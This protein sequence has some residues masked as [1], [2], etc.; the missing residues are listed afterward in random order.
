MTQLDLRRVGQVPRAVLLAA[1]AGLVLATVQIFAGGWLTGSTYDEAYHVE[2]FR[3]YLASGYYLDNVQ[4]FHGHPGPGVTDQYVY[5]PATMWLLHG[6]LRLFGLEGAGQVAATAHAYAFRHLAIGL[7]SVVGLYAV[8]ATGKALFRRWDWGI[9]AAAVVAVTPMW[10]GHSMFNL[11]DIPVATG[12]ALVTLALVHVVDERGRGWW[13]RLAD[14]VALAAG[15]TLCVGT[16]PGMWSGMLASLVAAFVLC[17][18]RR[19]ADEPTAGSRAAVQLHRLLDVVVGVAIAGALLVWMYPKVFTHP[20]HAALESAGSSANFRGYHATWAYVPV[21]VL[22]HIPLV[23][24]GFVLVGTVLAVRQVL[25]THMHPGV[26]ETQLALVLVQMLTLP[27][28]AVVKTSALYGDLRQLLFS[29]TATALVAT[30]GIAGVLRNV[31]AG[32]SVAARRLMVGLVCIGLVFPVLD[33]ATLFPFNYTYYTALAKPSEHKVFGDFYRAG[34]RA[35]TPLIPTPGRVVCGA[36]YSR[37]RAL[38]VQHLDGTVD[39]GTYLVSP[40]SPYAD[41]R[42]RRGPVLGPDQYY[43]LFFSPDGS[44]SRNCTPMD[45]VRRWQWWRARFTIVRLALCELR[46]PVL[47]DQG[48]TIRGKGDTWTTLRGGWYFLTSDG[49]HVR[50]RSIARES[51][52]AFRAPTALVGKKAVLQVRSTQRRLPRVVVNG[53]QVRARRSADG[54]TVPLAPALTRDAI[55]I[56]FRSAGAGPLDMTLYSFRME[57]A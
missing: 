51:A 31:R 17:L 56:S 44:V 4:Y 6:W 20:V 46:P 54:L 3:N 48:I 43:V 7:L 33:Q 53:R 24:L 50:T 28:V 23:I 19:R 25:R 8:A 21:Q 40:I 11:K 14:V 12:Y 2:R 42:T 47:P 10:T 52:L 30:I 16:R 18:V 55:R 37:D 1:W 32:A 57:P 36:D 15:F 34:G 49:D 5:G 38:F 13:A 41:A 27:L 45:Q 35:I 39:C 29:M 22:L 9:V 26:Q